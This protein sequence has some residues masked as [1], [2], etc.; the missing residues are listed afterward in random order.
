MHQGSVEECRG[1]GVSGGE[2]NLR[3]SADIH[4][5]LLFNSIMGESQP[6]TTTVPLSYQKR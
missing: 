6:G 4:L 3:E 1:H 2:R 5:S